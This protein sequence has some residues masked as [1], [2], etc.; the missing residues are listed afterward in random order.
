MLYDRINTSAALL[1][2][3]LS[4]EQTQQLVD[5][6]LLL[7]KWNAAYNLSALKAL[8]DMLVKHLFD[9]LAVV[10]PI[11]A[12]LTNAEK[13]T[14]LDV[15]TGAGLPGVVLAVCLPQVQVTM[16]DAVQ[17]K[18]TFV[19]QAIGALRLH[20]AAAHGTRV[21]DWQQTH[22]VITARAWTAL[23]D[24]P[25]LTAHCVAA[26]GCIAAMKGPRLEVEAQALP[27][28][29]QLSQVTDIEVPLLSEARCLA[30]LRRKTV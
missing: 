18:V 30:V 7:H 28:D 11:A 12:L 5:Y 23:G 17:K 16:L 24:I 19:R 27:T 13:P 10:R 6:L 25:R 4:A 20:N 26:N 14:I 22:G 15:G 9:C 1:G 29:W 21:Q 2:L 8:D 3:P